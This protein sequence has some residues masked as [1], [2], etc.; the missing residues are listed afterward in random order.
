MA[1]RKVHTVFPHESVM[2]TRIE[3][4]FESFGAEGFNPTLPDQV[5]GVTQTDSLRYVT[6]VAVVQFSLLDEQRLEIPHLIADE[7]ENRE[8]LVDWVTQT[9][10]MV[11]CVSLHA[12]AV[13]PH[14]VQP[15]IEDHGFYRNGSTSS[16]FKELKKPTLG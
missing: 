16:L 2:L 13:S 5:I 6:G 12:V 14:E 11:G 9:A 1:E 15:L 7:Q 3:Q 10:D 4:Y 8:A